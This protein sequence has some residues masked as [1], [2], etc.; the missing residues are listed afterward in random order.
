MSFGPIARLLG[1]GALGVAMMATPAGAQGTAPP[2][3]T[4]GELAR[5]CGPSAGDAN[6][7]ASRSVCY[8]VLVTVGQ[9]HAMYTTG[10]RA[11]PPAFCMPNPSPSLEQVASGF[12]SWVAA[13]PQHAGTRAVEGALRFAAATYPCAAPAARRR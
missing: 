7:L 5:A 4:T 3:F 1:V 13:N 8:A 2:I 9:A 11:A 12:V 6:A 10:S